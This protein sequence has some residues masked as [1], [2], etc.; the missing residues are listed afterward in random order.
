M[1]LELP[2]SGQ[3]RITTAEDLERATHREPVTHPRTRALT[4]SGVR[5]RGAAT[6]DSSY[7]NRIS[8]PEQLRS[9]SYYDLIGEIRFASQF[10]AK[11]L[12]RVRYYPARQLED[13][14]TEP[15]ESGAPVEILHRIQD[16]GGGRSRLQ[17]DYGRMMF[18]TGEGVLF[19]HE[20][21]GIQTARFLWKD[22]VKRTDDGTRWQR[23]RSDQSAY[24]P[25]QE[26]EAYRFWTPHPRHS[27]EADWPLRSVMDIAEEL[28]ILTAAVRSTAVSRM[29]NGITILPSELSPNSYGAPGDD[30][31]LGDEDPESNP[32]MS[33]YIEHVSNQK[34]NPGSAEAAM[35]F[36]L[37]GAYDYIDRVRW[38]ATHDPQTDY[39]E[40]ELRKEAV[41]RLAIG[42]DFPP[43]FL[44]GMTDANHWT[45]RQ[46]VYDMW[47]S[48][49]TP[50]AERF[51]DDVGD[52]YLR[53]LL[54]EEGYAGWEDVVVGYDDSKVVIP[55]DMTEIAKQALEMIAV[56]RSGYRALAGIDDKYAPDED[57]EAFLASLKMRQAVDVENGEIV[58]TQPG[59]TAE[60][61]GT[62]P[63]N[64]PPS[65]SGG[66]EVSRQEARTA[67]ARIHG[68]A[69]MAIMRCRDLAG[70]RIRQRCEE[71]A[72]GS[73]ASVVASV[74]G[75]EYVEDPLK[76]VRGG[77]DVFKAWLIERGF[78]VSQS[79]SLCDQLEVYAGRTLLDARCPELPSGFVAAIE[80][81]REVSDALGAE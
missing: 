70:R 17:Y 81:A 71:C 50:V 60:N 57:E 33:D 77:A 58:I 55:P 79:T 13:G 43:E 80:Q 69:E 19:L 6:R 64:G 61:N 54:E 73:P 10:Y 51:A 7:L 44:L 67:S 15:I 52:S 56:G 62:D 41:W 27:D 12:S 38:M 76:L 46:V 9:L 30:A 14:T 11:L 42:M 34:E 66:R 39:M 21:R 48:Y 18:V 31:Y 8:L 3:I 68:A 5:L 74:M 49:G 47:R 53:P 75:A 78:G 65:P 59:P 32:F 35:S 29:T 37:E 26:G 22:E 24:T 28:L 72:Q 23:V 40:K 2:G 4:A 1:Y 16:P 25:P 20:E 45:A 36:T 63:E